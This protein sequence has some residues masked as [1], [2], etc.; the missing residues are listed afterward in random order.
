[1]SNL[2]KRGLDDPYGKLPWLHLHYI[3][4]RRKR[5]AYSV[6][7]WASGLGLKDQACPAQPIGS[8]PRL[9]SSDHCFGA[10]LKLNSGSIRLVY[11]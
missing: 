7:L 2:K 8:S 4:S 11:G 10:Y 9:A 5:R 1:V 3:W 6:G